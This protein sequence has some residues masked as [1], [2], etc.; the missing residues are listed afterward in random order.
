MTNYRQFFLRRVKFVLIYSMEKSDDPEKKDAGCPGSTV[1]KNH[2]L[3][4]PNDAVIL[5]K[6]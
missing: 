5:A 4:S 1:L 2:N 6:L 3:T